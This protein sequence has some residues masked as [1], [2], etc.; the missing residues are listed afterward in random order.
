MKSF[1]K[2]F[3]FFLLL[4]V[5]VGTVAAQTSEIVA[6]NY[7]IQNKNSQRFVALHGTDLGFSATTTPSTTA[8]APE[9]WNI[10]PREGGGFTIQNVV[11]GLKARSASGSNRYVA[12]AEGQAFY[13]QTVGG[14]TTICKVSSFSGQ[15]CWHFQTNGSA[16]VTWNAGGASD[17]ILVPASNEDIAR[18]VA[19]YEL[20]QKLNKGMVARLKNANGSYLYADDE[21]NLQLGTTASDDA[22]TWVI[23]GVSGGALVRNLKSGYCLPASTTLTTTLEEK[24]YYIALSEYN[25]ER[26]TIGWGQNATENKF[27]T[28]DNTNLA[29]GM[30]NTADNVRPYSDWTLETIAGTSFAEAK[31]TLRAKFG[32]V[33]EIVSG[34]Y[35]RIINRFYDLHAQGWVTPGQ[36]TVV[37]KAEEYAQL[38]KITTTDD[39]K[40]IVQNAWTGTYFQDATVQSAIFPLGNEATPLTFEVKDQVVPYLS[41][42]GSNTTEGFHAAKSQGYRIVRWSKTS[43]ASLWFLQPAEVNEDEL[44]AARVGVAEKVAMD[45]KTDEYNALLLQYFD[46]AACTK[47]KATV[48]A[49]TDEQLR[50]ELTAKGL[51]AVLVDMVLR[52]KNTIWSENTLANQYEQLFRIANYQAHSDPRKWAARNLVQ[53]RGSYSLL[54]NPTGIS[55][56]AGKTLYVFVDDAIPAT[57]TLSAD[58]VDGF[59]STGARQ[60]L[61]PGLNTLYSDVNQHLYIS[62]NIDNVETKLADVPQILIHIEGGYVNGAFHLDRHNNQVWKDLQ[63]LKKQNVGSF[64]KDEVFRMKSERHCF[65]FHLAGIEAQEAAGNWEDYNG[66]YVGLTA[67]LAQWDTITNR[68]LHVIHADQFYDRY[69]CV[70]FASSASTTTPFAST[71]GTW[72]TGAANAGYFSYKH[73]TRGQ[74]NDNGAGIWVVAHEVGHHYQLNFNLAAANESSNN[75]FS[76][77]NVWKNGSNVSRSMPFKEL[78]RHFNT[79]TG[80]ENYGIWERVRFYWQL[81]LYFEELG[82]RP[83]FFR[84][85]SDKLRVNPLVA[86]NAD[87]DYLLF[88]RLCSEVAQE[89]LTDF[90]TMHGFFRIKP[91]TVTLGYNDPNGYDKSYGKPVLTVN[92]EDIDKTLN[93]MKT[94]EKKGAQNLFFLDERIRLTPATYEGAAPGTMRQ[95]TS[96][97][98]TPGDPAKVGDVGMYTDFAPGQG[99]TPQP[100]AVERDGNIIRI[101]G[102]G[103][104]GYKVYDAAGNLV[105]L[106]NTNTFTLPADLENFTVKVAGGDGTDVEVIVNGAVL[107][108]Y[109]KPFVDPNFVNTAG[110][111]VSSNKLNPEFVYNIRN[112]NNTAYYADAV[113]HSTNNADNAGRFAFFPAGAAGQY[114]MAS[115]SADNQVQ[116]LKNNGTG[117]INNSVSFVEAYNQASVWMVEREFEGSDRFDIMP[118]G[119]SNGWNWHGGPNG[120]HTTVGLW[121]KYDN[122]TSW[123]LLPVGD[124]TKLAHA[125][126]F[127]KQSETLQGTGFPVAE[128]AARTTVKAAIETAEAALEAGEVTPEQVAAMETALNTYRNTRTNIVELEDGKVYRLRHFAD[129]RYLQNAS[130]TVSSVVYPISMSTATT[131]TSLWVVQKVGEGEYRLASLKGDGFL[132]K[133]TDA[134]RADLALEPTTVTVKLG[135]NFGAYYLRT[136]G[137]TLFANSASNEVTTTPSEQLYQVNRHRGTDFY[138]EAVEGA[139]FA[140]NLSEADNGNFASIFLPFAVELPAGVKAYRAAQ[141]TDDVVKATPLSGNVLPAMTGA[142]LVGEQSGR[143]VLTPAAHQETVTSGWEGVL[144]LTANNTLDFTNNTYYALRKVSGKA[145]LVKIGTAS[146]PANRAFLRVPNNGGNVQQLT[147]LFDDD[148]VTSIL[149]LPASESAL[150]LD[151]AAPI[152]DLMGRRVL[153]PTSGQIYLQGGR[154]FLFR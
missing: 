118:S 149:E 70:L 43:D 69:N 134:Q 47:M 124:R 31:A 150:V 101:A 71:Y 72:Y 35:Y 8:V 33:S 131:N 94:F 133:Q 125:A 18:E 14:V 58:L 27:L 49:M 75:L 127:A 109:N 52:V 84:D 10:T 74:L 17:M 4:A 112:A 62:Y 103:A 91:G 41:I 140:L 93:Y 61:K 142:I 143:A 111:A 11:T 85:L 38:W 145:V 90:F 46:D 39:G 3:S 120:T 55:V 60:V 68:E 59:N 139:N 24:L 132:A 104:V 117:A 126:A 2:L 5:G 153:R 135:T 32:Y 98:A 95:A 92:Q 110:I 6:G 48:K 108:P 82:H 9:I 87:T 147:F 76:E 86:N 151:I 107:E 29:L 129:K 121:G 45:A 138:F 89:D 113:T 1:Y 128:S 26:V 20:R 152:Y 37:E 154:K 122:A 57:T 81:W 83:N 116:W 21:N 123:N 114:Y 100:N 88:A 34:K 77:I 25:T 66:R 19:N 146:I 28:V 102:T 13:I 44:E 99:T 78:V 53:A 141:P 42:L 67:V 56:E 105:F 130:V 79:G 97:N 96:S 63:S 36:A 144:R 54:T 137:E 12:D 50:A 51:P 73:L 16:L 7:R 148:F 22:Y 115:V 40:Y 65:S 15:N 30:P 80:W 23:E 136:N 64:M 106:A 119:S